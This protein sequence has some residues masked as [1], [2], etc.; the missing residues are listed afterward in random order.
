M[1]AW[2]GIIT[3]IRRATTMETAE[4]NPD[5]RESTGDAIDESQAH[6]SLK[7]QLLGPSLTK[8]GQDEVDQ[9]KVS[10]AVIF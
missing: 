10:R 2:L 4:E 6:Q 8:A 9:R 7:Y 1:A 5:A 3:T